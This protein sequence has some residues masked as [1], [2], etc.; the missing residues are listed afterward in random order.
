MS[1]E[2]PRLRVWV[3]AYGWHELGAVRYE[4][5]WVIV[6][7]EARDKS[8]L[9]IDADTD[10]HTEYFPEKDAA[11]ARAQEVCD[12]TPETEL[13]FGSIAI[14]QQLVEW[15][16][17][18]DRVAHWQYTSD[19]DEISDTGQYQQYLLRRETALKMR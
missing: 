18:E 12:T 17:E 15:F 10:T 11:M 5:Q 13:C 8:A 9:D 1:T 19:E 3:Y 6:K 7:P 2:A 16:V 4:A 14:Q